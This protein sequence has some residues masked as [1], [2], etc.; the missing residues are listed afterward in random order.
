MCRTDSSKVTLNDEA[1]EYVWAGLDEIMQLDLG[2][3]TKQFFTEYIR[4]S[5]PYQKSI[6]YQYVQ[7]SLD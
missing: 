3:Y 1:D 5:S 7:D 2:G 6:F 4:Q